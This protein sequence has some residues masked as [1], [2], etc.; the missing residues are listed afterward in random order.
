MENEE[1]NRKLDLI[2]ENG[3]YREGWKDFW[4]VFSGIIVI[5]IITKYLPRFF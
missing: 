1:I 5:G 3:G 4:I 2:I